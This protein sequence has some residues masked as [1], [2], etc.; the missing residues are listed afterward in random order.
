MTDGRPPDDSLD[1][2]ASEYALGLL[3]A[4]ELAAARALE[5]TDAV[6]AQKVSEW[7]NQSADWLF[8]I[9][10]VTPGPQVWD[11]L[12]PL[13]GEGSAPPASLAAPAEPVSERLNAA[14]TD[15]GE[16]RKWRSRAY[17]AMAASTVL[18]VALGVSLL[19][20]GV[21]TSPG[22][23][24]PTIAAQAGNADQGS[25]NLAAAQ[26]ADSQGNT[27]LTA[28]YDTATGE[29]WVD[30]AD[31]AD[32]AGDGKALELWALDDSG[33]PLSLGIV[34]GGDRKRRIN[35]SLGDLL[36]ADR[37]IALTFED[38]ATAPHDA[39]TGDILGTAQMKLL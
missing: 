36:V 26:I 28:L 21:P 6:F 14:V 27:L 5:E 23:S 31:V 19:A 18:A 33:K 35:Q 4:A 25:L 38:K 9:P 10:P 7:R 1:L 39:P 32:I 37:I 15:L 17:L 29:L 20:N 24:E 12:E 8:E 13:F 3:D 11:R 2:L 16:F 22:V 34:E 30:V